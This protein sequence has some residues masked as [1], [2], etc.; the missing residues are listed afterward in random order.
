MSTRRRAA[1]VLGLLT[2]LSA[3]SLAVALA[4][5]SIAVPIGEVLAA[6]AGGETTTRAIVMDLRLPRAAAGFA[7]GGLLAL[8]GCLNS[9]LG[10]AL[11]NKD[12][13]KAQQIASW[14]MDVVGKEN[15]YLEIQDPGL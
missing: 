3:A 7:V 14:Y 8:S 11:L 5:G 9:E 15:Y 6:L 12:A 4:V 13:A 1:W 10:H 2:L